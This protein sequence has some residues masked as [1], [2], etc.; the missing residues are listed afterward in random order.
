MPGSLN[1]E[2]M[3]HSNGGMTAVRITNVRRRKRMLL[4]LRILGCLSRLVD[5]KCFALLPLVANAGNR[6]NRDDTRN[7]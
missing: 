4:P 5:V 1:N 3:P 2:K 6:G 7:Y